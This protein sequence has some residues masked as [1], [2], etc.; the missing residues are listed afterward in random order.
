MHPNLL[1]NYQR[2]LDKLKTMDAHLLQAE[3][4]M[5]PQQPQQPPNRS[6]FRSPDPTLTG[7]RESALRPVRVY[8]TS[9]TA[10]F[11]ADLAQKTEGLLR[12]SVA[13]GLVLKLG[14]GAWVG[15]NYVPLRSLSH[16]ALFGH[17]GG[18]VC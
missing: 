12:R 8:P 11:S 13:P 2:Q 14:A 3:A 4:G 1:A 16:C 17:A 18:P 15:K 9:T 6:S 5:Q 7:E 10:L